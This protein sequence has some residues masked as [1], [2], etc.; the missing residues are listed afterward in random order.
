MVEVGRPRHPHMP[1]APF[2]QDAQHE[3]A[4]VLLFPVIRRPPRP[5]PRP[6]RLGRHGTEG[7]A[8]LLAR[9]IHLLGRRKGRAL[10]RRRAQDLRANRPGMA[11][12]KPLH[13]PG[14]TPERRSRPSPGPHD[15]SQPP[16]GALVATAPLRTAPRCNR[17]KGNRPA[18]RIRHSHARGLDGRFLGRPCRVHPQPLQQHVQDQPLL[19]SRHVDR[20]HAREQGVYL[21]RPQQPGRGDHHDAPIRVLLRL[22]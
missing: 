4:G 14:G 7:R 21:L 22:H 15:R 19:G 17:T 18:R 10:R 9:D 8:G 12:P 1:P 20:H 5:F 6:F 13:R 3:H 2:R 16:A 11:L